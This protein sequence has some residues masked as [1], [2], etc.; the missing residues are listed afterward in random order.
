VAP[1][2][3]KLDIIA[4]NPKACATVIADLGYK[5][6][7]CAHPFESVVMTGTMRLL[8]DPDEIRAGMRVL[9]GQLESTSGAEE[10]YARNNLDS[11]DALKRFRLLVFE[12]EDRTAKSGE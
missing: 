7:E 12:I 8:E 11:A 2:G 9:I 5:D 6:G 4:R 3:R 10:I 1:L